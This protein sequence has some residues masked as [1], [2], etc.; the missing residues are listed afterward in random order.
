[1]QQVREKLFKMFF[2]FSRNFKLCGKKCKICRKK[3]IFAKF[4]QRTEC[5]KRNFSISP[6]TLDKKKKNGFS[7]N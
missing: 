1:M 4:F 2:F 6:E 7:K 5:E 3:K